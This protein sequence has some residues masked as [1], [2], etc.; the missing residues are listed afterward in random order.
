MTVI[1]T[2]GP[3]LFYGM[4]VPDKITHIGGD[5]AL[6]V[7]KLVGGNRVVDAMGRDDADI[8][9]SGRFRASSAE[10]RAKL[11]DFLRIQG[12]ALD[13]TWSIF[14]YQVIIKSFV[15]EYTNPNEIPYTISCTVVQDYTSPLL[16]TLLGI[17]ALIGTDLN[18]LLQ[19]ATALNIPG[20]TKA[21]SAVSSAMGEVQTLEGATSTVISGV[22]SVVSVAATAVDVNITNHNSAVAASGNVAGVTAGGSP[23]TIAN[24]LTSQAA[25]FNALGQLYQAKAMLGRMTVNLTN[26]GS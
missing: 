17:D 11:V 6:V 9:W 7:H 8:Q 26:I 16:T 5:H 20:V 22:Q 12:Q 18:A 2:L 21:V 19:V 4:E 3:V 10:V 15:A 24:G 13:L 14:R 23:A 1:L 25:S